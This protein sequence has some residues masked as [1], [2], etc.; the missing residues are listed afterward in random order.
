MSPLGD[1]GFRSP[2]DGLLHLAG[3]SLA[4]LPQTGKLVDP[5]GL[6]DVADAAVD[7]VGSL[8]VGFEVR[9]DILAEE[10]ADLR[11]NSPAPRTLKLGVLDVA[12]KQR[13][14]GA[15]VC[16][17]D[18]TWQLAALESVEPPRLLWRR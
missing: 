14:L 13:S 17:M 1:F 2:S 10:P 3:K 5:T 9:P 11:L 12:S 16:F 8:L 6:L 15:S 7:R 18:A 4:T